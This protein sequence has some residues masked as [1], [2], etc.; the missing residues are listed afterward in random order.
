MVSSK[1]NDAVLEAK[2]L[3]DTVIW[4]LNLLAPYM[5]QLQNNFLLKAVTSGSF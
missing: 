1:I 4:A 5:I 3:T 2:R